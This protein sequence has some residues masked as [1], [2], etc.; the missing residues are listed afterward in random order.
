MLICASITAAVVF[1]IGYWSA[2]ET[3]RRYVATLILW[4]NGKWVDGVYWT[5]LIEV[6]FYGVVFI[7]LG[8]SNADRIEQFGIALGTVSTIYLIAAWLVDPPNVRSLILLR[9]GCLFATG[10]MFWTIAT[11]G[12]NRVRTLATTIFI[13]AGLLEISMIIWPSHLLAGVVW[14]AALVAIAASAHVKF[15]GT[16]WT[17]RLGLMT[18]PLYLVHQNVGDAILRVAPYTGRY[19][20]L[21]LSIATVLAIAFVVVDLERKLWQ[22]VIRGSFVFRPARITRPKA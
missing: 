2:D 3:L 8:M 5:L 17:R 11:H 6:A 1:S 14:I 10:I 7:L 16:W 21:V 12:N 22:G 15:S 4:P 18:Y 13:L 20:A 19:V 9:H